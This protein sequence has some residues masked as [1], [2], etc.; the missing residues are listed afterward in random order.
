MFVYGREL[1]PATVQ[2]EFHARCAF[3]QPDAC[4]QFIRMPDKFLLCVDVWYAYIFLAEE[5]G[6]C[7]IST[8]LSSKDIAKYEHYGRG[9][10][11]AN[12]SR[13][14]FYRL[15]RTMV[16]LDSNMDLVPNKVYISLFT[17]IAAPIYMAYSFARH[18]VP[19][20]LQP[21]PHRMVG[22]VLFTSQPREY[23][24]YMTLLSMHMKIT[25][26]DTMLL[27]LWLFSE[28]PKDV[29]WVMLYYRTKLLRI[30]Y[31]KDVNSP[32]ISIVEGHSG[33]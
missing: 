4:Y 23:N 31:P 28:L 26:R 3:I 1:I 6:F 16:R 32:L 18:L 25:L 5:R 19:V 7:L 24:T 33:R 20:P 30:E 17:N 11:N 22:G 27:F 2:R 9:L 12:L 21:V 8:G 29:V 13:R 10:Y 14:K 15:P